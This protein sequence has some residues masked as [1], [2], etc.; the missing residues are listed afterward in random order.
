MV[1]RFKSKKSGNWIVQWSIDVYLRLGSLT[2]SIWPK[3]LEYDQKR[4][5]RQTWTME[6]DQKITPTNMNGWTW[7]KYPWKWPKFISALN[8]LGRRTWTVEYDQNNGRLNDRIYI[9]WFQSYSTVHV[10]RCHTF[11]FKFHR[12][13]S[14]VWSFR[15]CTNFSVIFIW[16]C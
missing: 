1:W 9:F 14:S 12:S 3:Q 11:S 13:S 6:L 4:S 10:C 16:S 8:S 5:H 2:E 15:S 7:P